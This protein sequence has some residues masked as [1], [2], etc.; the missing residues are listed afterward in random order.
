MTLI[1]A[2]EIHCEARPFTGSQRNAIRRARREAMAGVLTAR[3]DAAKNA[4]YL[5]WKAERG[6]LAEKYGVVAETIDFIATG[7][8]PADK[9]TLPPAGT[10]TPQTTNKKKTT[11]RTLPPAPPVDVNVWPIPPRASA[12]PTKRQSAKK[13]RKA[14]LKKTFKRCPVCCKMAPAARSQFLKHRVQGGA[15]CPGTS[16]STEGALV[17]PLRVVGGGLPGLGRR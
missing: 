3:S 13:H 15:I 2:A 4:A 14:K 17:V 5:L 7:Y 1:T 8:L 12:A 11:Q 6:K 10:W 16:T 9:G